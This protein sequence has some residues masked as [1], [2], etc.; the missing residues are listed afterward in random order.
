MPVGVGVRALGISEPV[1]LPG[2]RYALGI[3]V[4]ETVR[5]AAE[6]DRVLIPPSDLP[7]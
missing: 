4:A 1:R 5:N 3:I 2:S 6:S 7:V